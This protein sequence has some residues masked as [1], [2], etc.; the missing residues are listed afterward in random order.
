MAVSG[1]N[2]NLVN[3]CVL[4]LYLNGEH[5]GLNESSLQPSLAHGL[6]GVHKDVPS[7]SFVLV[8]GDL[9]ASGELRRVLF[10]GRFCLLEGFPHLVQ[11]SIVQ[12][13]RLESRFIDDRIAWVTLTDAMLLN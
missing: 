3:G 1:D 12:V 11:S 10:I 13:L 8:L 9:W 2:A 6:D 4:G 5:R 7:L